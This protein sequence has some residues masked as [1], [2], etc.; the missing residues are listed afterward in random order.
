MKFGVNIPN[1]SLGEINGNVVWKLKNVV[2]TLNK[3]INKHNKNNFLLLLLNEILVCSLFIV[4]E[5]FRWKLTLSASF[6]EINFF[7]IFMSLSGTYCFFCSM[8]PCTKHLPSFYDQQWRTLYPGIQ[9]GDIT[10]IKLIKCLHN[11]PTLMTINNTS[12]LK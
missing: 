9:V 1:T 4:D 8:I 10:V 2:K 3:T 5:I 11:I 6:S 7:K 12:D